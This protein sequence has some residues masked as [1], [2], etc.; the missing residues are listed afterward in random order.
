MASLKTAAHQQFLIDGLM[1]CGEVHLLGG[2]S[3]VGKTTLILPMLAKL[4]CGEDIFGHAC[5][6]TK[7][8][9][10]C[11]DRSEFAY[12]RSIE[13]VG[14]RP[15]DFTFYSLVSRAYRG[16]TV[17]QCLR[18]SLARHP[19]HRCVFFEAI[20]GLL[21]H[22]AGLN[23]YAAVAD[24]LTG[25][26]ISA[27]DTGLTVIASCHLT[28]AKSN[29]KILDPRQRVIGSVAWAAFADCLIMVDHEDSEHPENPNRTISLLPRDYPNH[30]FAMY[31]TTEGQL[32]EGTAPVAISV[33]GDFLTAL[34]ALDDGIVM[35]RGA[36]EKIIEEAG[37]TSSR[38]MKHKLIEEG[39]SR[40]RIAYEG[41]NQY[42]I[43]H[44]PK[45]S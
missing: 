39:K 34:M 44:S 37:I 45:V 4:A 31:F 28:K 9:I 12:M 41:R 8:T 16:W 15:A 43:T 40:G 25:V 10:F 21:P 33:M 3:G 29:E 11:V 23:D 32:I 5:R 6:P 17:D 19:S 35:T 27:E 20:M 30:E 14:L 7:T 22:G 42:R 2:A 18:F 38:G 13:R 1:P 24:F 26:R 36:L